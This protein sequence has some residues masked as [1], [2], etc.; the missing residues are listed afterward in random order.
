MFF[1]FRI[2]DVDRL[3]PGRGFGRPCLRATRNRK[4][5]RGQKPDL[6]LTFEDNPTNMRQHANKYGGLTHKKRDYMGNYLG[7]QPTNRK[8]MYSSNI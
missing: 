5:Q 6:G 1:F 7:V 8:G 3:I 2:L 4:S